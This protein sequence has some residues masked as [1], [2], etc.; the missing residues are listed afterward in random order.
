MVRDEVLKRGAAWVAEGR[1]AVV[2]TIVGIHGSSSE[3]LAARMVVS[4]KE[5]FGAVSGGC[6]E[7][8]VREAAARVVAEGRPRMLHYDQVEDAELDVGLNCEGAIDVLL[9]PLERNLADF[10]RPRE[11]RINLTLCNPEAPENPRVWHGSLPG[12]GGE[13]EALVPRSAFPG[14]EHR[15]VAV[16]LSAL[17]DRLKPLRDGPGDELGMHRAVS[18][19]LP[20]GRH[21]LVEPVLPPPRL[22][23][24]GAGDI[25]LPLSRLAGMLGYYTVISDPRGDYARAERFPEA[26]EVLAGRP[27]E[28][29]RRHPLDPRSAVVSLNHEPR[30]EDELFKQ[31]LKEPR[32]GYIGAIGKAQRRAE[33]EARAREAGIDLSP[34][35]PVHTPVGLDIG[36]KEPEHIALS[37]LSEIVAVTHRRGGGHLS[38]HADSSS[39]NIPSTAATFRSFR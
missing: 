18:L 12:L 36:G 6:V 37:I 39:S 25:A 4:G 34:L 5:F 2:A 22:L 28:I 38:T 9:E 1:P 35:E 31:L 14:E 15:P 10:L 8:D 3:P 27:P 33:R 23:V 17:A 11:Y 29:L 21:A 16:E 26:D 13:Q 7:T 30:F 24:F 32:P 20:G 19:P